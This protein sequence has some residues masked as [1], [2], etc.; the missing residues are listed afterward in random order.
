MSCNRVRR[1]LLWMSRFGE[2][3]P[4]S[5]EHLDHLAACR[6]CRDEIGFD[7]EMVRQLRRA[8]AVRIEGMEP[9]ARAWE[10][11]RVLAQQPERR[12]FPWPWRRPVDTLAVRRT[13]TAMAGTG[14]AVVLAF[15]TDVVPVSIPRAETST[16]SATIVERAEAP[17]SWGRQ[18]RVAAGTVSTVEVGESGGVVMLVLARPDPEGLVGNV[19]ASAVA[20]AEAPEKPTPADTSRVS[21]IT[22]RPPLGHEAVLAIER[23]EPSGEEE[24]ATPAESPAPAGEP[25]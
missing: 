14:L 21:P 8:L 12:G 17:S 4:D 3:G 25:T 10:Q 19:D 20:T 6:T 1:E 15:N 23:A 24:P 22:V 9:S 13:L 18:P 11:V 5:G 2:L 16:P 7:R